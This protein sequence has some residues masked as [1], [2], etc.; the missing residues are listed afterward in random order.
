MN[1]DC[2]PDESIGISLDC[3]SNTAPAVNCIENGDYVRDDYCRINAEYE[4]S[5]RYDKYELWQQDSIYNIDS[6]ID[7][8]IYFDVIHMLIG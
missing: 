3:N 5:V 8:Q 7:W 4:Q 6:T 2:T 1:Y